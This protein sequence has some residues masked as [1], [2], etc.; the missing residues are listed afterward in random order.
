MS[1]ETSTTATSELL[2]THSL[3]L[4]SPHCC[5]QLFSPLLCILPC[6]R[7]FLFAGDSH[8]CLLLKPIV[9]D[10]ARP[11]TSHRHVRTLALIRRHVTVLVVPAFAVHQTPQG[12]CVVFPCSVMVIYNEPC[13]PER[14]D[15]WS[16]MM[17]MEFVFLGVDLDHRRAGTHGCRYGVREAGMV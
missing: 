7:G 5:A 2:T 6:G 17:G 10:L 14:R 11:L 4:H 12:L 13:G 8:S 1:L 15:L 16:V 3:N 9:L